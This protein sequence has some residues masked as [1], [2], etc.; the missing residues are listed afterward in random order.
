MS[1]DT[2]PLRRAPKDHPLETADVKSLSD[3]YVIASSGFYAQHQ[4]ADLSLILK[5]KRMQ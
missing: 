2:T 5:R 4:Y 1:A 3:H